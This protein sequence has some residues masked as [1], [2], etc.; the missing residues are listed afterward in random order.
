MTFKETALDWN[1]YRYANPVPTRPLAY[2]IATAPSG[3]VVVLHMHYLSIPIVYRPVQIRGARPSFSS[4]IN[5]V[6]VL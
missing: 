1:R 4:N 5:L 2:D 3:P 6:N